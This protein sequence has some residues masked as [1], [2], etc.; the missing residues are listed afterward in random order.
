MV[1]LLALCPIILFCQSDD[2]FTLQYDTGLR[3]DVD[4]TFSCNAHIEPFKDQKPISGLAVSGEIILHSDS[5]LVRIILMD[6]KYNE[7]LIYET[8]PVLAGSSQFSLNEVCEESCLLDNV[9]SFSPPPG[10][11]GRACYIHHR[12]EY[13]RGKSNCGYPA[14]L[15]CQ[16]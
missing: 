14:H 15:Q 3:I 8:Y 4:T 7:Y 16:A 1:L 13:G 9:R 10:S 5:S 6:N 12:S 2:I 11:K